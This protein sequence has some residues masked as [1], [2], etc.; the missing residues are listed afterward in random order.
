MNKYVVVFIKVFFLIIT[1]YFS[2]SEVFAQSKVETSTTYIRMGVTHFKVNARGPIL[3]NQ[4]R[5]EVASRA[6]EACEKLGFLKASSV[7]YVRSDNDEVPESLYLDFLAENTYSSFPKNRF[8]V[9]KVICE[10]EEILLSEPF[11]QLNS[12]IPTVI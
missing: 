2:V 8:W 12:E 5:Q 10:E 1:V 7:E 9:V 4:Q 3:S 11:L 6:Q